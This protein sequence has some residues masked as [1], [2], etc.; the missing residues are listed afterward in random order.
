MIFEFIELFK[1]AL[2]ILLFSKIF[3]LLFENLLKVVL[4]TLLRILFI[5]PS[6]LIEEEIFISFINTLL[7]SVRNSYRVFIVDSFT[8]YRQLITFLIT[9]SRNRATFLYI[10][11]SRQN[12]I[13]RYFFGFKAAIY[14]IIVGFIITIFID[15][16]FELSLLLRLIFVLLSLQPAFDIYSLRSIFSNILRFRYSLYNELF[17]Y[18]EL[19]RLELLATSTLRISSQKLNEQYKVLAKQLLIYIVQI[20]KQ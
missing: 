20:S 17:F 3:Q 2:N 15:P 16:P 1:K 4:S 13:S 5:R 10:S 9:Y 14:S 12:L 19:K 11:R 6:I 8:N 18:E 7:T